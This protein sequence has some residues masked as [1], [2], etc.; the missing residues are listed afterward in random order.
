MNLEIVFM[1][2]VNFE[3]SIDNLGSYDVT[4]NL[5]SLGDVVESLKINLSPNKQLSNFVVTNSPPSDDPLPEGGSTKDQISTM[6]YIYRFINNGNKAI[7]RKNNVVNVRYLSDKKVEGKDAVGYLMATK[8]IEDFTT[9]TRTYELTIGPTKFAYI[10]LNSGKIK[11][12]VFPPQ[13]FNITLTLP[14]DYGFSDVKEENKKLSTFQ[15]QS[16]AKYRNDN[17]VPLGDLSYSKHNGQSEKSFKKNATL[18]LKE[19]EETITPIENPVKNFTI[20][21]GFKTTQSNPSTYIR[22]G[23]LLAYIK[24]N[25][26]P[27]ILNKNGGVIEVIR[28]TPIIQL[29]DY[30]TSNPNTS[31]YRDSMFTLP[32]QLSL[33][34]KVCIV[35]NQ[36]LRK[37]P[38]V[39]EQSGDDNFQSNYENIR[40]FDE[41]LPF[42]E[43]DFPEEELELYGIGDIHQLNPN[44]A[45]IKNIYLNSNFIEN[46]LSDKVDK[47][48]DISLYSFLNEICLGINRALGG[49]NNLEPIIDENTNELY[50][51]DS[52]PIPNQISLTP[53]PP[54]TLNLFG[55]DLKGK[56]NFLRKLDIKTTISPEYASMITIGSTSAGYVKGTNGTAFSKWNKG[57]TDRFKPDLSPPKDTTSLSFLEQIKLNAG[58]TTPEIPEPLEQYINNY[59][60]KIIP[61]IMG[62][63]GDSSNDNVLKGDFSEN[64]IDQNLSIVTEFYKFAQASKTLENMDSNSVTGGIGFIPFKMSFTMNGI[65]GIKIY[66]TLHVNSSF[67]PQAY[68]KTLDFIIT[69]VDHS[70]KSNDWETTISTLVQPKSTDV[71]GLSAIKNY[72]YLFTDEVKKAITTS[73][74]STSTKAKNKPNT[75]N[76][77]GTTP[78]NWPYYAPEGTSIV[79]LEV[80]NPNFS[81][82]DTTYK[83]RATPPKDTLRVGLTKELRSEYLPVL[84]NKIKTTKGL[85]ILALAMTSREGFYKD[86]RSYKYNNP[87]NIGNTDSGANQGFPSLKSGTL[88]Q[89][90]YLLKVSK[91]KHKAYPLNKFKD[92]KPFYSK[93]IA[94]NSQNYQLTPYLPGY[95]FTYSGKLSQFIKIY[96]TG[97]RA[98]N[99]Y[100][101][102]IISLYKKNGF[103]INEDTTLEELTTLKGS[104]DVIT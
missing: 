44:R 6:L 75:P 88:A 41:L 3:W 101:S 81:G 98:G 40:F 96:S 31:Y 70:I 77:P 39:G 56:G 67:L 78:Q 50:L 35:K 95:K 38:K 28:G 64:H 26:I 103:T 87:G 57:L 62:M 27:V 36:I 61:N 80:E 7:D 18:H 72:G 74:P 1:L 76:T 15:K 8:P 20:L 14:Y 49:I 5:I 90:N 21:D 37:H 85:K 24:K 83:G 69:G 17:L 71:N 91:G 11:N 33:D 79:P 2:I 63:K 89:L 53:S 19:I 25:I 99:N 16:L 102:E 55:F 60:S 66:N 86:T 104:G 47:K 82:L 58:I 42:R 32:N 93:E 100:L 84:N 13:T 29:D 73:N 43:L 54:Y 30:S 22:L 59:N 9:T 10:P 52:T 12:I 23:A 4:L 65:E 34:P 46:L 97:A 48:G 51:G 45:Y 92:I 94:K 68:G